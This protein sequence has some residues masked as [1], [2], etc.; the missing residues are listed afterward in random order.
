MNHATEYISKK[1]REARSSKGL[2]QQKLGELAGVPQSHIS[3][4]ENGGVDLR[5]SSLV[6]LARALDLELTLV[7]RKTVPAVSAI[8]RSTERTPSLSGEHTHA[9]TKDLM[10][11]SNRIS[12][13]VANNPNIEAVSRLQR[14]VR[15][16]QRFQ[17]AIPE[18]DVLRKINRSMQKF[19]HDTKGLDAVARKALREIQNLRNMAAH[20]V[21]D[22]P[23]IQLPRPAY[24]LGEDDNG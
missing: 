22:V 15:D 16:L 24:A 3:K 8:V 17:V 21:I 7:P 11:L 10:R 20:A 2:S 6:A 12:K 5:V 13:I 1:L 4:I 23:K 14:Q 18:S 19:Q 9:M